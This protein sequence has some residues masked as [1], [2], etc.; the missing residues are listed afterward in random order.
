MKRVKSLSIFFPAYND[1]KILPQLVLKAYRIG[2]KVASDFE[3]IIIDDGS[4]DDTSAVLKKLKVQ[5]PALRV[6]SHKKNKGYG[7]AL[8][9]GFKNAKKEWVFYT[10]GD[11]QYDVG[12]L[13][14]LIGKVTYKIDVVNG[15]KLQ[16]S[17]NLV[18]R[19]VG[20]ANN[21][22]LH[23]LFSLPIS[24]IDCDF[25]LIRKSVLDR[26]ELTKTSGTICLELIVKLHEAGAR[27]AEVPVHHYKRLYGKSQFFKLKYVLQTVLDNIEFYFSRL[28]VRS[29]F[30]RSST[31]G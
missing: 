1:A 29:R 9:S 31:G 7:G 21:V 19:F 2:A 25:R 6:I 30:T 8:I 12:E 17:D 13:P 26:V 14:K 24:D 3:V 15:F 10:D 18:R 16:R 5:Y 27:F 22:M 4:T 11:G 20:K 28:N 23:T